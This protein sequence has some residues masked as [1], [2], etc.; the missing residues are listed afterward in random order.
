MNRVSSLLLT[1]IL[2]SAPLA[3]KAN[4]FEDLTSGA[5]RPGSQA[6]TGAPRAGSHW[7]GGR[8]L[9]ARERGQASGGSFSAL[10]SWYGGGG[11]ALEPN[12]RTASGER[13]DRWGMTAAHRTLPLGTRLRVSYRGRTCVVRINDR[14]PAAWTGRSL[15]LSRGAAAQ[16]GLI[17]SGTGRVSVTVLASR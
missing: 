13:F 15:D 10:A 7:R 4:I 14:G 1:I 6:A 12:S 11:R 16:L 5:S 2:W 9:H 8:L 17:A 3:A